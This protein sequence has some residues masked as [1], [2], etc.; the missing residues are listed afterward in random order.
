MPLLFRKLNNKRHWDRQAWLSSGDAPADALSDLKTTE[1]KLSIFLVDETE[2]GLDRVVAASALNRHHHLDVL[3]L[4]LIAEGVLTKLRIDMSQSL[5][6][7]PDA[8]VNEWHRDLLDLSASKL[9][10]LAGA[11][12]KDGEIKRYTPKDVRKAIEA[13]CRAG[14]INSSKL[15]DEMIAQLKK[16]QILK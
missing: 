3:D 9:A 14:F 6:Q 2:A 10:K 16:Q 15:K 1:N 13:S 7:T 12:R 5:G 8:G 11:I 4:A